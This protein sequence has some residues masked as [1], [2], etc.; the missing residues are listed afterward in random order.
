MQGDADGTGSEWKTFSF[1]PRGSKRELMLVL[2]LSTNFPPMCLEWYF[3]WTIL[4]ELRRT[5]KNCHSNHFLGSGVEIKDVVRGK[6][7]FQAPSHY[8]ERDFRRNRLYF[9][10]VN[11]FDILFLES[12]HEFPGQE[13]R[14][15]RTMRGAGHCPPLVPYWSDQ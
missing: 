4:Y 9:A 13:G 15:S 14:A 2:C 1:C 12:S 7:F 10:L 11:T 8:W 6:L 5:E 3:V